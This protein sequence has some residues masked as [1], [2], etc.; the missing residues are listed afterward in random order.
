MIRQ[1]KTIEK[2]QAANDLTVKASHIIEDLVSAY[3]RK[4]LAAERSEKVIPVAAPADKHSTTST[5]IVVLS[6]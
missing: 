5:A 1:L 3:Q 2:G 4:S 6:Q